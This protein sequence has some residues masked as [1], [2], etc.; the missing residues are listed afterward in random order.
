VLGDLAKGGPAAIA[1]AKQLVQ[2]FAARPITPE[3]AEETARRIARI[4][5]AEEGRE[6]VAAFLE[7]RAPHWT[8]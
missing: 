8:R 1:A 6:G 7:K 5:A 4:R 3:I 2:D